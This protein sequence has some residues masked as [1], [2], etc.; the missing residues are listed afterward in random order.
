LFASVVPV[1]LYDAKVKLT[2]LMEDKNRDYGE[3]R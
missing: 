2:E 1:S 3:A